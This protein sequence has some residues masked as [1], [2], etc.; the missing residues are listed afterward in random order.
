M[1]RGSSQ[2]VDAEANRDSLE[3]RP[4]RHAVQDL[5]HRQVASSGARAEEFS[6]SRGH[7]VYPVKLPSRTISF[8]V[9]ELSPGGATSRHRH[10]YES[11]VYVLRGAGHTTVEDDRIEWSAGD[12]FYVPPWSWH[13]HFADGGENALY[14]T[15]TNLPLLTGVG[16]TLLREEAPR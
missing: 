13:Q 9:G 3:P 10:A 1:S 14:L 4:E 8:S 16:Q 2:F 11:L 6:D 15:A 5:V 7:P 12:A